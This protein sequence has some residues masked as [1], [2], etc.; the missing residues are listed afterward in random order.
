MISEKEALELMCKYK[1]NN[2]IIKH[3]IGVSQIAYEISKKILDKNPNI[4][5]DPEKTKLAGLLHD[6]WKSKKWIHEINTI[7]IL[8]KEKLDNIAKISKHW[9]LYEIDPKKHS[10]SLPDS[11]ENKIVIL[12]DM[13]CNQNWEKV[14]LKERF[15]DIKNRYKDD[16]EFIKSLNIAEYRIRLIEKEIKILIWKNI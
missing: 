12:S 7:N 14:S 8:K 2:N 9:F 4:N 13:Y 10:R 16:K 1:L 15:D 6:I 5:I 11:L 3:C